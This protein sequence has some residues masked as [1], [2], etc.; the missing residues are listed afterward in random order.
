[1]TIQ[2][3][4]VE[5][6]ARAM[7][8]GERI[9]R[10][11][12]SRL[13]RVLEHN[14]EDMTATVEAGLTLGDFQAALR[15][16]K[17]WA[18]ID[19]P[20]SG[21]LSIVDLLARDWSGPRRFGYGTVREHVIGMRMVLGSGEVIKAGGKVVKNVAG[22][23]LCRLFIGAR[24]SLGIIVEAAFKLRPL[25]EREVLLERSC[26]SFDQAGE[27]FRTIRESAVEPI[28]LDL[29]NISGQWVMVLGLAGAIEDVEQQ[30]AA[31]G[32]LGFAQTE[33]ES[34]S[35]DEARVDWN[36]ISV[37]PTEALGRLR[38]LPDGLFVAR[39]GN[40]VIYHER[41]PKPDTEGPADL[42]ARVKRTYDP[43]NLLP[44]YS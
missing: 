28:V 22:Y 20:R 18:P 41:L 16:H 10:A 23:D 32:K 17:Q 24:H 9:E 33:G 34:L 21:G 26:T 37:L 30:L 5:D 11:D 2:P 19:P 44:S 42:M 43:K 14:P 36:R 15:P 35:Y 39:L 13:N 1:M 7:I 31:A 27:L 38:S 6:L 3:A 8:G 4:T 12:L 29:H 40:G 25:P